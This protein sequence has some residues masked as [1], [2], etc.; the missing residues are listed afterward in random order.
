MRGSESHLVQ[1]VP[2]RV[3][4]PGAPAHPRAPCTPPAAAEAAAPEAVRVL[5]AAA[6][7]GQVPPADVFDAMLTLDKAKVKEV[8]LCV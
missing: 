2:A 4:G 8:R 1:S 5:R 6:A 7:T 3:Q